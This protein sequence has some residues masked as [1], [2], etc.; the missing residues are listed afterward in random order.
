[1]K[2][3]I[4]QNIISLHLKGKLA[5][6]K[7]PNVE[8]IYSNQHFDEI[9]RSNEPQKYL[10]VLKNIEATYIE[11]ILDESFRMTGE[12]RLKDNVCPHELYK[13]H[14]EANNDVDCNDEL[15]NPFLAWVNG[16]GDAEQLLELPDKILE[17]IISLTKPLPQ[18]SY[19]F[20]QNIAENND[21]FN[22]IVSEMVENG[23]NIENTR[24]AFTKSKSRVADINGENILIKI[25]NSLKPC[26]TVRGESPEQFFGFDPI[27][28]QGFVEFPPY[29]GIVGCCAVLD[30]LGYKSES[31]CRKIEKIPNIMSDA[32][33]IGLG[34]FCDAILSDDKKLVSRAKAIYEFVGIPTEVIKF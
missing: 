2:V 34:A 33:H 26:P 4:D 28:K 13:N 1:M 6:K 8:W 3:Y 14:N 19:D 22:Q 32:G 7:I 31:K 20:V 30:I 16:G 9:A 23:N 12:A 11:L 17:Q 25:W 18:D 27:D 5:L 15:F 24:A 10:S 21:K 29:L